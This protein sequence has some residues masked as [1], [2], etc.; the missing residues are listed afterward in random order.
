MFEAFVNFVGGGLFDLLGGI[1][2]FLPQFDPPDVAGMVAS[3]GVG[4]YLG[5]LNWFF[6]VGLALTVTGLWAAAVL[7]YNIFLAFTNWLK[8]FK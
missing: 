6:P 3:S 7:A 1:F 8:S 5:Y 2:S 4:Q